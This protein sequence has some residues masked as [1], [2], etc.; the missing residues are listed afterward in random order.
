MCTH[1][2]CQL[3]VSSLILFIPVLGGSLLVAY[4]QRCTV[5]GVKARMG[6][7]EPELTVD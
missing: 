1:V 2:T 6:G 5:A 4:S 3:V 7:L